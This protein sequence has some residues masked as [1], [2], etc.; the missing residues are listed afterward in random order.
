VSILSTQAVPDF[1][2]FF[3]PGIFPDIL[4]PD[5]GLELLQ[6]YGPQEVTLLLEEHFIID[7]SVGDGDGIKTSRDAMGFCNSQ[8]LSLPFSPVLVVGECGVVIDVSFD[9]LV[10]GIT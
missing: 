9:T 7:G 5:V 2:G 4:E 8:C 3:I 1:A 6:E 10:E